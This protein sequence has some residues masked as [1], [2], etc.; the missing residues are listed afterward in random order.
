MIFGGKIVELR[1]ARGW[2]QADLARAARVAQPTISSLETG[3]Q[4]TS[5]KLPQIAAAL[6]VK[7]SALDPDFTAVQDHSPI[8]MMEN[9]ALAFETII[10][11]LREDLTPEALKDLGRVFVDLVR[12]PPAGNTSESRAE[13]MRL[14]LIRA[15]IRMKS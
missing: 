9:A 5:R 15:L 4:Q 10:R 12:E 7:V 6:G 11:A 2:S 8:E 1:E 3:G 13:E 14:R